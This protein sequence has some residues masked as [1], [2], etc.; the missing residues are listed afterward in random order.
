M[1]GSG[2]RIGCPNGE[3]II[4]PTDVKEMYTS[5]P[6]NRKSITVIE[7]ICADGLPPP[8]PVIICPGKRITESWI[9]ASLKGGDVECVS[10]AEVT[11]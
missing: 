3:E 11:E 9:Q 8:P 7:V 5:S 1:D 10:R 6:E 4:V 2:A